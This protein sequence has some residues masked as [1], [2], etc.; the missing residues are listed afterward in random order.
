[1]KK[2]KLGLVGCGYL[3]NIIADAYA[4]N[5]LEEY[6]IV[7]VLDRHE[8][9]AAEIAKKTGCTACKDI[10]ELMGRKPDFVS[11]TAS[12]RII[13]D[14]AEKVLAGGSN[15]VVL[16]IG[17]FADNDFYEKIQAVAKDNGTKVYLASGAIGGFDVLRTISLMGR[18]K[19]GIETRKGPASLQGTPLFEQHL[20]TDTEET[21]VFDG[22]AKKAISLL[23]TKVN[24]AVATALATA[25]AE[26]TSVNIHSVPGMV[27][28]DHKITAEIDGVRAVVD[29]YSST[30]EIAGWSIVAL[31]RNIVSP[32]V[33]Q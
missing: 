31:L 18:V 21:H 20:M 17:A 7:G 9:R 28:D 27:G 23:P 15:L 4:A 11:E 6:E 25:G 10:D 8:D 2:L 13:R 29:I 5:L 32:V 16:S 12:G 19:A 3:G 30:S 22:N 26:N 24:V 14:I 1:M 33:F